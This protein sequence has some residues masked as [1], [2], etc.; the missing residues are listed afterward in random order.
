M[1][2]PTPSEKNDADRTLL[3][4]QDIA[5]GVEEDNMFKE[6]MKNVASRSR[7]NVHYILDKMFQSKDVASWNESSEF[8]SNGSVIR[9]S[10]IFDLVK[11]VTVSQMGD[12]RRRPPGWCKF[13]RAIAT[14]NIPLSTVPNRH[15]KDEIC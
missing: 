5:G 14:L 1:S 7:K 3:A 10:H 15:V 13:I 9:G 12:T 2:V 11:G 6:V 4:T 8:I